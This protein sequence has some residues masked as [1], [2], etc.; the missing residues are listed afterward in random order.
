MALA[1]LFYGHCHESCMGISDIHPESRGA[2]CVT[3]VYL[4]IFLHYWELNQP[5]PTHTL[6]KRYTLSYIPRPHFTFYLIQ[7]HSLMHSLTLN[8]PCRP[9]RP[10]PLQPPATTSK[11]SRITDLVVAF[12][13]PQYF[14]ISK[15]KINTVHKDV[16]L[17][18]LICMMLVISF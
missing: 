18:P 8:S 4:F 12:P 16:E 10:L 7:Y 2:E 6:S 14:Y 9:G 11:V 1:G 17:Y 3:V 13:T 5:P 15:I